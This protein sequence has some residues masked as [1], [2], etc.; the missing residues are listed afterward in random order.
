M[1]KKTL[2]FVRS[3][4]LDGENQDL[5]VIALNRKQA[6]ELWAVY[7]H[8]VD[9]GDCTPLWVGEV[10]GVEPT[11]GVGPLAWGSIQPK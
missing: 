11:A 1:S 10:P 5:L 3:D 4:N 7:F 2:Y 8:L 9:E 6:I